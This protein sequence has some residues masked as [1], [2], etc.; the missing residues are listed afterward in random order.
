MARVLTPAE[1]PG[2]A[3]GPAEG[4]GNAGTKGAGAVWCTGL[5]GAFLLEFLRAV[6]ADR[7]HPP[8]P[9]PAPGFQGARFRFQRDFR[10]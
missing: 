5:Q 4:P 2:N 8:R 7:Q 1:G 3:E 10:R 6:A 9:P